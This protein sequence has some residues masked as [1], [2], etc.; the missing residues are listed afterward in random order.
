VFLLH[1]ETAVLHVEGL[2]DD[3]IIRSRSEL[4][5]LIWSWQTPKT[6]NT[7]GWAGDPNRMVDTSGNCC[8][9]VEEVPRAVTVN[10]HLAVRPHA[11]VVAMRAA[12]LQY[13]DV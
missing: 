11:R 4:C 3:E 13:A 6:R 7:T 10:P 12:S 5:Y 2:L 8:F 1:S 9:E